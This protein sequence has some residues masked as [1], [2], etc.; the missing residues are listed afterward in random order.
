MKLKMPR[1]EPDRPGQLI[2]AALIVL[3]L[4]LAALFVSPSPYDVVVPG[5][6]DVALAAPVSEPAPAQ[7][8]AEEMMKAMELLEEL[9][10]KDSWDP[11]A[12]RPV[13]VGDGY[14][15]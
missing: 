7:P 2:M 13:H 5:P 15:G 10:R 12:P 8:T 9:E 6:Y 4:A 14:R 11:Y 3:P 1:M